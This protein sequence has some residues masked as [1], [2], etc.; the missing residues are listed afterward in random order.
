D[1]LLVS[2]SSDPG[3]DKLTQA[4]LRSFA[5]CLHVATCCKSVEVDMSF[6]SISPSPDHRHD[7]RVSDDIIGGAATSLHLHFAITAGRMSRVI[8]GDP[9]WRLDYC[10]QGPC[11][12]SLGVLL[13]NTA[14][15]ELG[16]SV[17]ALAELEGSWRAEIEDLAG[18]NIGG[19]MLLGATALASLAARI[20][21][22]DVAE[23]ADMPDAKIA[24][25]FLNEDAAEPQAASID[26]AANDEFARRFVNHSLLR[27]IDAK[28]P[29]VV[30]RTE[31]A[32]DFQPPPAASAVAAAEFRTV[33]TI[34]VNLMSTLDVANVQVI[35]LSFLK[36]LKEHNGV[37][38]QYS[39]DDKGKTMLATL[40]LPS[41]SHVNNS[42]QAVKCIKWFASDLE[43]TL[44]NSF[45]EFVSISI[46]SGDILFT[47]LG[48]AYR[49][50]IGLL[51]DVII[52]AARLMRIA[53]KTRRVVIDDDTNGNVKLT[54]ATRDLG[55]VRLKGRADDVRIHAIELGGPDSHMEATSIKAQI[56]YKHERELLIGRFTLWQQER[57][58][59]VFV[60]EAPS[61]LGKSTLA[62]FL[63]DQA[64]EA[65][66]PVCLTQGS[67]MDQW[68]PF[69]GLQSLILF[70]F[71]IVRGTA[72]RPDAGI[73]V[74][75]SHS[76][77]SR[78]PSRYRPSIANLSSQASPLGA[79][80]LA[81]LNKAGVDIAITP[82]L[83]M[84]A[85]S[86]AM[87]ETTTTEAMDAQARTNHLKSMVVKIVTT[88]ALEH[89]AVIVFD[90]AQWYDSQTLD[91]LLSL[92]WYCPNVAKLGTLTV[93]VAGVDPTIVKA[94]YEKTSGSPLFLQMVIDVLVVKVGGDLIVNDAGLLTTRDGSMH[95]ETILTDLSAA[96]LFQFDR[97][98]ATFQRVLKAAAVFGQYFN[99]RT[100]LD[101][102]DFNIDETK[103]MQ[104]IREKDVYNFLIY[105]PPK[106]QNIDVPLDGVDCCFRHISIMNAIYDSLSFEERMVAHR[107]VGL[108]N[109][110]FLDESNREAL[111]P[112]LEYHFS[113]TMET[114]KIVTYKEELGLSLME[115]FQCVEGI[116]ILESLVQYVSEA[117]PESLERLVEPITPLRKASW[118]SSLCTGYMLLKRYPKE[119]D[120][121]LTALHLLD[122]DAW[123]ADDK[124]MKKAADAMKRRAFIN[125]VITFG[126]RKKFR[127][128]RQTFPKPS[129]ASVNSLR[130]QKTVLCSMTDS[131]GTS[132]TYTRDERAYLL[133][134]SADATV[135]GGI[136]VA[137][138]FVQAVTRPFSPRFQEC[139]PLVLQYHEYAKSRSDT[140]YELFSMAFAAAVA[141]QSGQYQCVDEVA[142]P[143]YRSTLA[144]Q[145]DRIWGL[146]CTSA[147][148]RVALVRG[149]APAI[150]EWQA[151]FESREKLARLW[152]FGAGTRECVDALA[153]AIKGNFIDA[154]RNM[155]EY[156]VQLQ[157]SEVSAET[158]DTAL[159]LPY[160][161]ILIADPPR[162]GLA[163]AGLQSNGVAPWGHADIS[164]LRATAKAQRACRQ[165]APAQPPRKVQESSKPAIAAVI[166]ADELP[167]SRLAISN[168][169]RFSLRIGQDFPIQITHTNP[170]PP[171]PFEPKLLNPSFPKDRFY[172][173]VFASIHST[174][175]IEVVGRNAQNGIEVSPL[176]SGLIWRREP[177][178]NKKDQLSPAD[179]RLLTPYR[180]PPKGQQKTVQ[181]ARPVVSWLKKNEYVS[182]EQGTLS[183]ADIN[184]RVA[185]KKAQQSPKKKYEGLSPADALLKTIENTFDVAARTQL[186]SNLSSLRH[187]TNPKLRCTEVLQVFPDFENWANRYYLTVYDADPLA[188][189]IKVE[190]EADL[191]AVPLEEALLK[192]LENPKNPNDKFIAYYAPEGPAVR[193]ILRKRKQE[194]EAE[195]VDTSETY[196]YSHV[197]DFN[198]KREKVDEANPLLQIQFR[199]EE[200]VGRVA[201][202]LPLNEKLLLTRKRAVKHLLAFIHTQSKYRRQ[203]EDQ[204]DKATDYHLRYRKF[205]KT[206]RR[207]RRE[208]VLEI[209]VGGEFPGEDDDEDDDEDD[210]DLLGEEE[211]RDASPVKVP[212]A[213]SSAPPTPAAKIPANGVKPASPVKMMTTMGRDSDDS[214]DAFDADIDRALENDSAG[215]RGN[216]VKKGTDDMDVDEAAAAAV[217]EATKKADAEDLEVDED[218]DQTWF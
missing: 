5:C 157:K 202:Y 48:T 186:P 2:F 117:K 134:R 164:R 22:A 61:G 14:C 41:F 120:A 211:F 86:L 33:A 181:M 216:G 176:A 127:P 80:V 187:P 62:N 63:M 102:L 175:P 152:N 104:L 56:G 105:L 110:S 11:M 35:F 12:R 30:R 52:T 218:G 94:M 72:G 112:S 199:E 87:T 59:A 27:R 108:M 21:G 178:V 51:G 195:D 133:M 66:V 142:E 43:R 69:S 68:R 194:E 179:L 124:E 130:L 167:C 107:S 166:E 82:L 174:T 214:D 90:D 111:L 37:F 173:E 55:M 148:Y 119:R 99:I 145:D 190:G 125:W 18:G 189:K 40:G 139:I 147:L 9:A 13:D 169:G 197:R 96:I 165:A 114:E 208:K 141:F 20:F 4:V 47:E 95:V 39:A 60:I 29:R 196:E 136:D 158:M 153:E 144:I 115:K 49:S 188:E 126:G 151:P 100:V 25:K 78:Q 205:S 161:A 17:E 143:Y 207:Q 1:A 10:V 183:K 150:L 71:S 92:M 38:L 75:R 203:D 34:F 129:G 116:R 76:T 184:A 191:A 212:A 154:L 16:I 79:A 36:A 180:E 32:K 209:M 15:G 58:R 155:E 200:G 97:L 146:T 172:K 149:D 213:A 91:V 138:L 193:K 170:L 98:D 88:F 106:S 44:G 70:I 128:S 204:F 77:V 163:P 57:K 113:R 177:F 50:E 42:D 215:T 73:S 123:P 67:E 8:L 54:H 162:S 85:S 217:A 168:P 74:T 93:R 26:I 6:A 83:G 118:F 53:E 7:L 140:S 46:A 206:E 101:Q 135:G 160:V 156:L 171:L 137:Y 182:I 192:P 45:T 131:L 121:A 122:L 19:H 89:M 64:K 23:V 109:E 103:C 201:Y 84:V 65:G 210:N 198:V 24:A 3:D 132:R 31:E 81:F 28:Q 159:T 185:E